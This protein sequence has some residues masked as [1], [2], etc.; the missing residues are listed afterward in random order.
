MPTRTNHPPIKLTTVY[1][2]LHNN[3]FSFSSKGFTVVGKLIPSFVVSCDGLDWWNAIK[4]KI[5]PL[6]PGEWNFR[7]TALKACLVTSQHK[8]RVLFDLEIVKNMYSTWNYV[9]STISLA[10]SVRTQ[11]TWSTLKF[12]T[13]FHFL[14]N[15]SIF[16]CQKKMKINFVIN[17]V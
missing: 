6:R 1:N 14:E 13:Q 10:S 5:K 11:I 9:N 16:S 3:L 12:N 15:F 8:F 4:F 17:I 2:V 7:C